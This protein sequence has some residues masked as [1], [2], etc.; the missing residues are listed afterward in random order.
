MDSEG[1]YGIFKFNAFKLQT[2]ACSNI[3]FYLICGVSSHSQP[4]SSVFARHLLVFI[5]SS[6]YSFNLFVIPNF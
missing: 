2:P 1:N 5:G 4:S 6:I 3:F